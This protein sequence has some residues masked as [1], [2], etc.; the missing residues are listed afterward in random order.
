LWFWLPFKDE[1]AQAVNTAPAAS[2]E[3][4]EYPLQTDTVCGHY[5]ET[6]TLETSFA[7]ATRAALI[8]LWQITRVDL[9]DQH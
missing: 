2:S 7:L 5:S 3:L 1:S 8:T 9:G 4:A 6:T